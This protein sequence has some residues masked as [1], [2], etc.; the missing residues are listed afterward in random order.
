MTIEQDYIDRHPGSRHLAGRAAAVLPNGVTHDSRYLRPFQVAVDRAAGPRKWDVD[1]N[2]YVDYVMG[3]GA[4]LLGHNHPRV[5][6][7]VAAQVQR[8]TH[9][10]A[11]HELEVRWAEEVVRLVPSAEVVR[12]TSSGTEATL[13]A[14]R[15][16]RTF[17]GRPGVLKFDR[18]FHGWHDYVIAGSRYSGAATPPGIPDATLESV[19]VVRPDIAAV[20]EAIT[21]RGD[22]GAIILEPAGASSGTVP[23]PP[24][25]L[26]DLRDLCTAEGIVFIMDEVVTGFRWSAGGV[27][28]ATGVTPDLT[29]L[30]KILAGGLPG[31]AVAG[32]REIMEHL[33]FPP[34]GSPGS[35][36]KVG[37]PG[38]FNANPLSASAGVACLS[39]MGDGAIQEKAAA[40]AAQLRAGMNS[41]LCRL[42][43]P[44]V[45]YGQ[46]S[47]LHIIVGAG[48]VP[49]AA[50]YHPLDVAPDLI[51][52][53][54]AGERLRLLQLAMLN[55]GV[56]LFGNSGFVS[57]VHE[58]RDIAHTVEAW[59][60]SLEAL[61]TEGVL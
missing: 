61:R 20:R 40:T 43:I 51:E 3:H 54:P 50:D 57:A 33:A 27:Q 47:D 23:L 15:L 55:R 34:P 35:K 49:E 37:H 32:R 39:Q 41:V 18:H 4:L 44:G 45:V 28:Q 30:A 31:G 22:I 53:G 10:G 14:L 60:G 11:S 46:A 26:A 13:M 21:R 8:G 36:A 24:G 12:F 2:E 59:A 48:T 1:G 19:A 56:H 16:A 29:T 5:L 58:E 38:T 6:E 52:Q 7:A 9:Y 25:F 17:T 42:G